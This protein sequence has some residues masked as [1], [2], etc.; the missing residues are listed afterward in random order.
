MHK[1]SK[2]IP[3]GRR[4]VNFPRLER[5]IPIVFGDEMLKPAPVFVDEKVLK[6]PGWALDDHVL[7]DEP[8]FHTEPC[9]A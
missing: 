6:I 5:R 9:R 3:L 4:F 2:A 1:M 7:M 8:L